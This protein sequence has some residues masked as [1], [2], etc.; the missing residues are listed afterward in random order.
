M[1]TPRIMIDRLSAI[2]TETKA[3]HIANVIEFANAK[4]F[5]D[6]FDVISHIRGVLSPETTDEAVNKIDLKS[7]LKPITRQLTE[8][9]KQKR[10]EEQV[11][12]LQ[13]KYGIN[14][15]DTTANTDTKK[16]E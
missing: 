7:Q 11:K 1:K 12:K 13:Q 16:G 4:K 2:T 5:K 15:A 10:Y 14:L 9:T 6:D 3:T 8:A